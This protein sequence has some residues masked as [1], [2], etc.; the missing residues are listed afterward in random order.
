MIRIQVIVTTKHLYL[1]IFLPSTLRLDAYTDDGPG[2]LAALF[3][4]I[5]LL[6]KTLSS[7]TTSGRTRCIHCTCFVE[8]THIM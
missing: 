8:G 3:A 1:L 4:G 5:I 2:Y 6:E 7:I